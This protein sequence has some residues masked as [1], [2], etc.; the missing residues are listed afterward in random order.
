MTIQHVLYK[1]IHL[2]P[3]WK[4][5]IESEDPIL[6]KS[7]KLKGVLS[8][9]VL[10]Q[11]KNNFVILDGFKRH[12]FFTEIHRS[13]G[14]NSATKVPAFL[15]SN[16]EA[17]EG[18]LH[19]LVLNV[20]RRSLSA[21]EK[22]NV[23]KVIHS[24]KND[25]DFQSQVYDFLDI[26][27]KR[28][29]IQKYLNISA[30]PEEAKQ[31]FH[32]F[33][34]S[35][36]QIERIMPGSI[37]ALR[38][39]IHLA[40]ELNIKAQEFVNLVEVIRDISIKGNIPVDALYKKLNI[41]EIRTGSMTKQQK[42][43]SLKKFLDEKRYPML[44]HIHKKVTEQIDLIRGKSELPLRVLWDKTLEQSGYELSIP[45]ENENS[46]DQLQTFLQSPELMNNLKEL[47]PI[48][49]NSLEDFDETT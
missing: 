17:K 36:R 44:K 16:Q 49:I 4:Y 33:Q 22:S 41:E 20:T 10:L 25:E 38:H 26:P 15:Y 18:F 6:I 2:D 45:L 13:E 42:V 11:D 48:I 24:H 47:F 9:L 31:Y 12:R 43:A 27:P 40:Q 39:W 37:Q 1:S 3:K 46:I 34:F 35:L 14:G 21:I 7:L 32:E 5:R 30:F 23:V 28:P 19:S 8:P 29:F